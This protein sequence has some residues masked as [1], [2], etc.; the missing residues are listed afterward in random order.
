MNLKN[1][2]IYQVFLRNYKD[3][4]FQGLQNDLPRIRE[5][6]AD[7]I[8]LLPIHPIGKLNRKGSLGS[9]YAIRDYRAID[10]SYGTTEDF[11]R[12]CDEA[13]RAGI[14]VMMDI[15]FNHTSPDSVL[16]VTH[17]EWFYRTADGKMGNRIG[18]W[19]DVVDLDYG[20]PALWDYQ[21]ETL[22][23]WAAYADGFRCDVAPMIPIEFWV[24]ARHAAEE[25]NPGIVFLAESGEPEFI[26]FLRRSGINGASDG[27]LYQ[28]FDICYD[29]DIYPL[30]KQVQLGECALQEYT[31]AVNRQEGIYPDRA[32]RMRFLENHDR[33]RAATLAANENALKN[34]TAWSYF[35]K[36]AVLVYAGQE[37]RNRHHPTLFDADPI[38]FDTGYDDS[39]FLKRLHD[40]KQDAVFAH[41]DFHAESRGNN[42]VAVAVHA[43]R[44]HTE[45]EG[46][47]AVGIF[48]FRGNAASVFVDLPD[49]QYIN[50]TDG[51]TVE[52]YEQTIRTDGLPIVLLLQ[53]NEP[54][55]GK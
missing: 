49:G 2:M 18:D 27:E 8:C 36:G 37:F 29:Y 24:K 11:R 30:Q 43:G 55:R 45:A 15:V 53:E 38:S 12:F 33:P 9:P 16:T 20:N 14:R 42:E 5:L 25:V 47:T 23:M 10:P 6:G 28:A 3:G 35:A 21:I 48:S 22:K 41:S 46:R 31:E 17:P 7:W 54:A 34:W 26:T 32:C 19:W 39:A 44:I 1:Q 52:V 13:H 40:I 51:S 4:T 50:Q